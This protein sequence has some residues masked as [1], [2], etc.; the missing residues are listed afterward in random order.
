[1]VLHGALPADDGGS[2]SGAGGTVALTCVNRP[3]AAVPGRADGC[4]RGRRSEDERVR[5]LQIDTGQAAA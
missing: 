5:M 2:S 3:A 1:M 4:G